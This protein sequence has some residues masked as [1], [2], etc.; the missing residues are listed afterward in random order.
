MEKCR[1]LWEYSEFSA[2]I[3]EN[4]KNGMDREEAVET[5]IDTCIEKDILKDVLLKQ[6]AEV[7]HMLLTHYDEKKHLRNTFMEGREEGLEEGRM[8]GREEKLR[9]QIQKKMSKGK[10]LT[11]IA[12]DLEEETAVIEQI[13]NKK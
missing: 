13:I 2:E 5:A 8:A 4:I 12:E 9:E 7:L 6:K 1:R 10:S 3:E 11:E